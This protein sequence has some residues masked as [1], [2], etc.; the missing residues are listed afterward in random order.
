ML[1]RS[2]NAVNYLL[3]NSE[4]K[5]T[6]VRWATAYALG[7]ILKLKTKLNIELLPTIEA[8]ILREENNGV[9]KKYIDAIK[10]LK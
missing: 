4:H 2:D 10:K 3:V 9:R 6:V 5:G 7:E 8:I 1:F